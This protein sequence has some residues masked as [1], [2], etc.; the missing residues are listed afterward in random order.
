MK[1]WLKLSVVLYFSF[2]CSCSTKGNFQFTTQVTHDIIKENF[3][4]YKSSEIK[5]FDSKKILTTCGRS[6]NHN[7]KPRDL[8]KISF[9]PNLDF[10]VLEISRSYK[11]AIPRESRY[12]ELVSIKRKNQILI[13]LS[14]CNKHESQMSRELLLYKD[15]ERYCHTLVHELRNDFPNSGISFPLSTVIESTGWVCADC[16]NNALR[17]L[18]SK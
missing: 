2:L 4:A 13:D 1:L 5:S 11:T 17:K 14:L 6:I 3:T 15:K 10:G 8:A 12:V 7:L 9:V 18:K 16:R